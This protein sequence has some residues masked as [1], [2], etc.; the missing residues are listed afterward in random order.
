METKNRSYL[1]LI[2][3]LVLVAS[4]GLQYELATAVLALGSVFSE[5]WLDVL[6]D[7]YY[8]MDSLVTLLMLAVYGALW[9]ALV[10]HLPIYLP[11]RD[12]TGQRALKA[13]A[14]G[15]GASG[16]AIL[17]LLL[18]EN[19][20]LPLGLFGQEYA[21]FSTMWED[22]VEEHYFW[23]ALSIAIAGPIF[24]EV[25]FRGVIY[26]LLARFRGGLFPV[27]VSGLLFGLWH[28][29]P[30]QIIYTS[31]LGIVLGF[32]YMRTGHIIYP[33]IMHIVN[34]FLST[35]PPSWEAVI[36]PVVIDGLSML[37]LIYLVFWLHKEWRDYR[38]EG[39]PGS[40]QTPYRPT[41]QE[42]R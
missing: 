26:Q 21:D 41:L 5:G 28:G 17:I 24:E 40:Q 32:V 35:L 36:P 2:L 9:Y 10:K 18:V 8:L 25:Y 23:V 7:R 39:D 12:L 42:S 34:N 4:F 16:L 30:V 27:V 29:Q 6:Y 14:L 1:Y 11:K 31:V 37:G 22:T 3:A 19:F 15:L 33:I 20:L 38:A 13:V